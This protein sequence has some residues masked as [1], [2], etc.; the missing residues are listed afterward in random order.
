MTYLES[1][2][3]T[4]VVDILEWTGLVKVPSNFQPQ[5]ASEKNTAAESSRTPSEPP[6]SVTP[7]EAGDV[8]V[9]IESESKRMDDAASGSDVAPPSDH[10]AGDEPQEPVDPFLVD[11][12][13]PDDPEKPVNWS[14]KKKALVVFE[15][16]FLTCSTYM[17]SSIYTPGQVAIQ[18]QFHVGHVTATLNLSLYV[19][20]YGLGPM[21]FSPLSEVSSIGRNHIYMATLF[22]FFVLQIGAALAPNIGGLITIR[23]ITGFFSS[24]AVSTGGATLGDFISPELLP[25]FIGLWAVGAVAAPV[26][27]PLLGASMVVAKDWRWIFWLLMWICAFAFTLLS[28]F[29]PETLPGNVLHRRAKRLRKE[30][31]DNR[32]YTKAERA[33]AQ[34]HI[35]PFL[36]ELFYRPFVLILSEPGVLAFDCYIALAYGCF[37]LFFE[38]YPI[39]FEGIYHFTLIQLGLSYFGFCVGCIIAYIVLVAFLATQV[40]PRFKNGTFVPEHFLFLAMWV[41]FLLPASLFLF[42]WTA[43]VHWILPIVWQIPF[44]VAV[45]NIFQC[46]FAYLAMNYPRYLASV[47]AGNAFVRSSFACAF[48]LFG[49]AMYDALAT[50]RFPV[51]WGSTLLGFVTLLMAAIPFVMYRYGPYLRGR[52]KYAN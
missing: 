45:F 47:F 43:Q 25:L 23:F 30:T 11:W 39:V 17:G 26:I 14:G 10:T 22:L 37:Y 29:F 28:F 49:Q 1:F 6:K 46:A 21:V 18:E 2:K 8:E 5:V 51:A 12:N 48:P 24:P 42:A 34:I 44:V 19:L 9:V 40:G 36:K 50:P 20:G 52:S 41:C 35:K 4:L 7:S 38:A 3:N 33:D 13:G 32:Y 15:V 27:A 16:M 31:G